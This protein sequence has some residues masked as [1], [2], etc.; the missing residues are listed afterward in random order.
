MAGGATAGAE[1][2]S[3]G[4]LQFRVVEAIVDLVE[5]LSLQGPVLVALE[6]LHWADSST[7][8]ALRWITRELTQVPLLLAA[9]LRPAPRSLEL[10]QFL[11]DCVDSA[12]AP[13]EG[14]PRRLP[15]RGVRLALRNKAGLPSLWGQRPAPCHR[16]PRVAGPWGTHVHRDCRATPPR[17]SRSLSHPVA[18]CSGLRPLNSH[19]PSAGATG[20]VTGAPGERCRDQLY[21]AE[22]PRHHRG[23]AHGCTLSLP[24]A[25]ELL[26]RVGRSGSCTLR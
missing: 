1:S 18:Q 26:C 4:A 20:T 25:H 17:R 21:R 15:P 16:R 5:G 6:D 2:P 9:T 24:L 12:A 23:R 14:A 19:L 8:L 3:A 7:L 13:R 11:D 10:G 22:Q